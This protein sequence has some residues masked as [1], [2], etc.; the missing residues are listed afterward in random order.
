MLDGD[1]TTCLTH[2]MKYPGNVDI[3]LVIRYAMHIKSPQ[4]HDCPAG[5]FQPQTNRP[6]VPVSTATASN[7]TAMHAPVSGRNEP[8]STLKRT[9]SNETRTRHRTVSSNG[10]GGS[11]PTST[12]A[13][14]STADEHIKAHLRAIQNTTALAAMRMTAHTQAMQSGEQVPGVVEGFRENVRVELFVSPTKRINSLSPH[15][16]SREALRMELESSRAV[17]SITR[18]KLTQYLAVLRSHIPVGR[19]A[20]S[21]NVHQALDGIEELCSLLLI[22]P[23]AKDFGHHQS[24]PVD[25]AFEAANEPIETPIA[26]TATPMHQTADSQP[27]LTAPANRSSFRQAQAADFE[28]VVHPDSGGLA[29]TLAYATVHA[30]SPPQHQQR[31]SS[32]TI[33]R[34][35][36]PDD[37]RRIS[38]KATKILGD[39]REV[40]MHEFRATVGVHSSPRTRSADH[41]P[42]DDS[43]DEMAHVVA[44]LQSSAVPLADPA[45]ERDSPV[46]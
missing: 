12:N 24:L 39:R 5:A 4:L 40:E 10:G 20:A 34:Y 44:L 8:T 33:P 35:E 9:S 32:D 18:F 15:T 41:Q 13:S 42:V 26:Q 30:Q 1:Y 17:M 29:D 6:P 25:R 21:D 38:R 16:Q 11:R 22:K 37:S 7:Q 46:H 19:S 43:N 31:R 36:I 2:L 14:V 45:G 28:I 3:V 23:A 27:P